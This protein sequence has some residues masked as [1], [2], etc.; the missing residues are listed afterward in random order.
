M[1]QL[2][3]LSLFAFFL[4]FAAEVRA[5][6]FELPQNLSQAVLSESVVVRS[7]P[8]RFSGADYRLAWIGT[9]IPGVKAYLSRQEVEWVIL[10]ELI[11]I[12]RSR[13]RLNIRSL[14]AGSIGHGGFT[15]AMTPDQNGNVSVEIPVALISGKNNPIQ[16]SVR[17]NGQWVRGNIAVRF[18]PRPQFQNKVA[19]HHP[20][21]RYGVRLSVEK[22]SRKSWAYVSCRFTAVPGMKG[23]TSALQVLLFWDQ[24]GGEILEVNGAPVKPTA[25]SLWQLQLS[26]GVNSVKLTTSDG[27]R[28]ELSYSIPE[29]VHLGF[30]S[31]GVGPYQYRYMGGEVLDVD[32][33]TAVLTLYA[34]MVFTDTIKLAAFN[35]TAVHEDFFTNQGLYLVT[36]SF[37]FLDRRV[38]GNLLLGGH[39]L[40]FKHAGKVQ[41]QFGAPQGLEFTVENFLKD[42]YTLGIGGFVQPQFSEESYYNTWVRWGPRSLFG[43]IN[44]ISWK[45]KVDETLVVSR[46]VGLS[47]VFPIASFF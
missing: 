16:I 38:K 47:F 27:Q 45:E 31:L 41:F 3:G 7:G 18:S 12:P 35:A 39:F 5:A 8:F 1:N 43:E 24:S 15:H 44:F 19:Y 11:K 33:T 10:S 25:Q 37:E 17:R 2:F 6:Q 21:T 28:S 22:M 20:C 42:H 9:P 13:L 30:F 29:K 36:E 23:R 40:I 14:E 34:G 46:S 26:P 32:T 4:H